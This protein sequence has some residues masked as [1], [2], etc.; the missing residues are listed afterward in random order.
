MN[1]TAAAAARYV[2]LL[3]QSGLDQSEVE[4]EE[5][6]IQTDDFLPK[7]Q[8]R[9][10]L[11]RKVL[12]NFLAEAC[13]C[14]L[15]VS[16]PN[17][18]GDKRERLI[19]VGATEDVA[20]VRY[21]HRSLSADILRS[22]KEWAAGP[23]GFGCWSGIGGRGG[24]LASILGRLGGLESEEKKAEPP[25]QRE[26]LH[27]CLGAADRVGR[28]AVDSRRETLARARRAGGSC[29]ALVRVDTRQ[30]QIDQEI[31][32]RFGRVE[33]KHHKGPDVAEAAYCAGM[34][35]G[36]ALNLQ[37]SGGELGAGRVALK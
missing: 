8:V 31:A 22:C 18:A 28:R 16:V 10:V 29:S 2:E 21:L 17:K 1:E 32:K 27:F 5:D 11:W 7:G 4:W 33:T 13:G 36:Q 12:L 20:T 3:T 19:V 9:L 15:L 34:A 24:V 30:E 35:A 23:R 14:Q 37:A 26:R 25:T 6:E